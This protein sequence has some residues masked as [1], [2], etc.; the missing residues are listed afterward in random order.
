MSIIGFIQRE[1]EKRRVHL[2]TVQESAPRVAEHNLKEAK[3]EYEV[4]KMKQDTSELQSKAR[5]MKYAK[6]KATAQSLKKHL[7]AFKNSR[8]KDSDNNN[9]WKNG[10]SYGG[11]NLDKRTSGVWGNSPDVKKLEKPRK[12]T[13]VIINYE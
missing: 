3:Q 10:G 11:N 1:K 5:G 9:P 6:T 13:K 2:A 8:A 7:R 12:K 4:A